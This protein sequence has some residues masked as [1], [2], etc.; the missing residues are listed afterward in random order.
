MG[1][2]KAHDGC[3]EGRIIGLGHNTIAP[4]VYCALTSEATTLPWRVTMRYGEF[5]REL[6]RISNK[7]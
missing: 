1:V 3:Q 6:V 7:G 2:N 4:S 5:I